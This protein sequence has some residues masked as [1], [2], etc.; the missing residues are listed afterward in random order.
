MDDSNLW[1]E[2]PVIR[3]NGYGLKST[4]GLIYHRIAHHV[5]KPYLGDLLSE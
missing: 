5:S 4:Q 2:C 1:I 3:S